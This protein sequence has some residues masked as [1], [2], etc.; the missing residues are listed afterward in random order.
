VPAC[1]LG[2]GQLLCESVWIVFGLQGALILIGKSYR[3]TRMP[4]Y[5]ETVPR[6]GFSCQQT[7]CM[8]ELTE[9]RPGAR[10]SQA[11]RSAMLPVLIT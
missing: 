9:P 5:P 8:R 6:M 4:R 3:D 10:C 7:L 2:F 1:G 11:Q